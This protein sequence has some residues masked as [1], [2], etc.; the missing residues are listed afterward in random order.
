[1]MIRRLELMLGGSPN[2]SFN[3]EASMNTQQLYGTSSGEHKEISFNTWVKQLTS[4]SGSSAGSSC[5]SGH[6]TPHDHNSFHTSRQDLNKYANHAR[7]IL[8]AVETAQS[9]QEMVEQCE[10]IQIICKDSLEALAALSMEPKRPSRLRRL[11][12]KAPTRSH[13]HEI[14][15]PANRASEVTD[16]PDWSARAM[17][18]SRRTTLPPPYVATVPVG[19]PELDLE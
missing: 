10:P 2:I 4:L 19:G 11:F 14:T 16:I 7:S 15:V 8:K 5:I 9:N 13:R 12:L 17:P 3:Q 18:S 6:S 1:M